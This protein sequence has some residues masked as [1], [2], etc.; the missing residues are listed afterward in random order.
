[1][2]LATRLLLAFVT[3]LLPLAASAEPFGYTSAFGKLYRVDLANG[4]STEIGRIGSLDVE[5]LAFGL[6]GQLYGVSDARESL[7]KIDLSTGVGTTIGNLNLN[8]QGSGQFNDLDFGL[9]ITCDGKFWLSA[10]QSDKVWNINPTTGV[11]SLVGPTGAHIT[12]LAARGEQLFG[13]GAN[14]NDNLYLINQTTGSA[15]IVGPIATGLSFADAGLDFDSNGQLW[16]VLDFSP[17][18]PNRVSEV[19]HLDPVTGAAVTRTLMAGFENEG[20]A[21]AP[22]N[23]QRVGPLPSAAIPTPALN[24]QAQWVLIFIFSMLGTLALL[25]RPN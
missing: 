2:R 14:G 17:T 24:I 19:A 16:A 3:L 21:I 20:L 1:M 22:T 25:R 12:G 6:D 4:T 7:L 8:G 9:A 23:C 11:A 13:I 18:D 5:G 15:S 10:D